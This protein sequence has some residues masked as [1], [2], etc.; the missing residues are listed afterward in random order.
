MGVHFSE[1]KVQK[2]LEITRVF[3]GGVTRNSGSTAWIL[4]TQV[5]TQR[6]TEERPGKVALRVS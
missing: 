2:R 5:C 1:E 4:S 6:D 3:Q